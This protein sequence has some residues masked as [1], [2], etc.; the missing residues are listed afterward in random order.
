MYELKQVIKG[1]QGFKWND[2][3]MLTVKLG[4]LTY[5]KTLPNPTRKIIHTS[6]SPQKGTKQTENNNL[7]V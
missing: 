2:S 4:N 5:Q 1:K 3:K 7:V 6:K